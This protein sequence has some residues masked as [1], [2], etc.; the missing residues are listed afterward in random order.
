M[1]LVEERDDRFYIQESTIPGA[2]KGLFAK[3]HI[4]AGSS[5]EIIGVQV[6]AHSETDACTAYANNY[7]FA[8]D[9]RKLDRYIVPLGYAGIVNHANSPETKNVEIRA[10]HGPRKNAAAGKMVYYF[11]KDVNPG[12]EI[13]GDYGELWKGAFDWVNERV[14]VLEES[15]DEWETF[16]AYDLYNLGSLKREIQKE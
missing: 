16:L 12:E 15:E 11:L 8:A 5:L 4:P 13:L 7:K 1:I 10:T 2:G 9:D 14:A 6:K 3:V